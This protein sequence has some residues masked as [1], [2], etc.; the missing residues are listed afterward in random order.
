M[1]KEILIFI[2]CLQGQDADEI[3]FSLAHAFHI[4]NKL[5]S[6]ANINLMEPLLVITT[7]PSVRSEIMNI[8][9]QFKKRK[10]FADA[11]G[12]M[13]WLHTLRAIEHP[14]LRVY[15][16][17]LW[18]QLHRGLEH[19]RSQAQIIESMTGKQV[20]IDDQDEFPTGL[21]PCQT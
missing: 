4:K 15:G 19:V 8:I 2:Q 7:H 16:R 14:E 9:N 6:R 20:F 12:A 18:A 21:E 1:E 10:E 5:L 11:A 3:G 13:I 17:Q